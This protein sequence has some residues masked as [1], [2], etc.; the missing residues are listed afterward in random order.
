MRENGPLNFLAARRA[1]R[2]AA[3]FARSFGNGKALMRHEGRLQ[4][5]QAM[6]RQGRDPFCSR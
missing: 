3:L 1:S 6:P 5:K 4:L 2:L